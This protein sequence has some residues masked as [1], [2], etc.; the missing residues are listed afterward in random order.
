MPDPATPDMGGD[1]SGPAQTTAPPGGAPPGAVP[2]G[3]GTDQN[4]LPPSGAPGAQPVQAAG[5]IALGRSLVAQAA[6]HLFAAIK[7]FPPGEDFN[8]AHKA[9]LS[10]NKHFK[11]TPEQQPQGGPQPPQMPGMPGPGGPMPPGGMGP[12]PGGLP[13]GPAPGMQPMPSV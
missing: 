7:A 9:Y 5:L 13:R 4:R 1:D 6:Q 8:Q 3:P 10:L 2:S 11:I 12:P